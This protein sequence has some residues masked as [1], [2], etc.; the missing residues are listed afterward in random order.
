MEDLDY[1]FIH[2]EIHL[3]VV[4]I[5]IYINIYDRDTLHFR[6]LTDFKINHGL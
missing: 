6:Y 2:S 3:S 1:K 4:T 5:N